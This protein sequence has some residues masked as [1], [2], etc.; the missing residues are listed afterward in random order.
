MNRPLALLGIGTLL[1]E[2]FF[3]QSCFAQSV[4]QGSDMQLAASNQAVD[5]LYSDDFVTRKESKWYTF[6]DDNATKFYKDGKYNILLKKNGWS[7]WS[8]AGLNLQDFVLEIDAS[9]E[10]GPDDN[11]YGVVTRYGDADNFSLF[12]I[13]GDGY[14][15]YLRKENGS[16]VVPSNWTRSEA[17]K[18]GNASNKIKVIANGEELEF[19]VNDALLGRFEDENPVSGDVGLWAESFDEGNVHVSFDNLTLYALDAS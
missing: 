17:I 8:F 2:A 10:G 4:E 6:S 18:T 19:Y 1:L 13:S 14:S 15:S 3:L 16:W 12:L 7:T 11:D 5:L 9:Q